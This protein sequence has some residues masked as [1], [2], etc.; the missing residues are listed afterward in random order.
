MAK[1]SRIGRGDDCIRQ[2][3]LA[4]DADMK[5]LGMANTAQYL[6]HLKNMDPNTKKRTRG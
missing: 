3:T 5:T 1:A 2:A 4:M 6:K